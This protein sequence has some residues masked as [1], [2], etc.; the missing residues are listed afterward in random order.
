MIRKLTT[1]PILIVALVFAIFSV[2]L[3]QQQGHMMGDCSKE[4]KGKHGKMMLNLSAEQQK[5]MTKLKKDLLKMADPIKTEIKIKKM[6][7]RE[8]WQKENLDVKKIL[9][10]TKEISALK[11][12]LQERMVNHRL[13]IHK[14]LT[15]EQRK[16]MGK[17]CSGFGMSCAHGTGKGCGSGSKGC[18]GCQ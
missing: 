10:T 8:L 12:K 13:A 14:L 4:G 11:A 6:E 17:G 1:M 15:P 5:E 9:A 2:G 3:A 16:M 7:L 18:G